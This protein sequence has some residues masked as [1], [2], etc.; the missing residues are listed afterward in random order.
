[1][2]TATISTLSDKGASPT[3]TERFVRELLIQVNGT[4]SRKYYK[5]KIEVEPSAPRKLDDRVLTYIQ[6]QESRY[7]NGTGEKVRV[8]EKWDYYTMTYA[9]L[10]KLRFYDTNRVL[11]VLR[12]CELL[13]L[14]RSTF[15][16]HYHGINELIKKHQRVYEKIERDLFFEKYGD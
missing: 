7:I 9:A 6:K 11:S 1:M 4:S 16:N 12:Y 10:R 14:R 8:Q 13:N 3:E 15:T 2:V 5:L